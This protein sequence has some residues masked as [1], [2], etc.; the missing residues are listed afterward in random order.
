[1]KAVRKVSLLDL[2]FSRDKILPVS[3]KYRLLFPELGGSQFFPFGSQALL[4]SRY[5]QRGKLGV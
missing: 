1:M 2:L 3:R 5:I 4:L